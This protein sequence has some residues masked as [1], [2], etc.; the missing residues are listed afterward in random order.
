MWDALGV[1]E[2]ADRLTKE[3]RE[4]PAVVRDLLA[5]GKA[6]FYE[7][8]EAA[9]FFFDV[10]QRGYAA[11]I[12]SPKAIH[13]PRLHRANRVV[14]HN[15]GASLLDRLRR[16]NLRGISALAD[17]EEEACGLPLLVERP[18]ATR[19]QIPNHCRNFTPFLGQPVH[20]CSHPEGVPHLKGARSQ[21]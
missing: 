18:F 12:E 5:S 21:L 14:K 6:S 13:L 7:E 15:A 20:C 8:R 19:Q 3:G 4:V 10:G 11:E 17:V 1:R 16:L 2:A 9:R